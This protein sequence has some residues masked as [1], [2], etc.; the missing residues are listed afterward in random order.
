MKSSSLALLGALALL[1][2]CSP[3]TTETDKAAADA[4][5]TGQPANADSAAAPADAVATTPSSEAPTLRE[6]PSAPAQTMKLSFRFQPSKDEDN[7]SVPK[8]SVHIMLAGDKSQDI[9][10]GRVA[11]KPDIVDEAKAKLANFPAGMIAG[12]RSYEPNSG[13]GSDMAVMNV[14]GR[15]LRILQRRIDEQASEQFEFKTAREV[16]LPPNTTVVAEVPA[17]KAKK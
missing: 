3:T 5:A 15:R 1:S 12:F 9:D 2:A 7:P 4:P 11:G 16:T 10:M 14:E 13:T 6:A 17:A 8:T